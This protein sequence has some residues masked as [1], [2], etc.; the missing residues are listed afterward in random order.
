MKYDIS[1]VFLQYNP[2]S[3]KLISSLYSLINQKGIDFEIIITDDGSQEDYFDKIKVF[4]ERYHFTNYLLHKNH[5]NLGIVKNY[6]SGVEFAQGEYVFGNSPGDVLAN[7]YALRD[8]YN[9]AQKHSAKCL[10]AEAAYYEKV[11]D[12]YIVKSC[13]MDPPQPK[14]YEW[15]MPRCFGKIGL[16]CEQPILGAVF[17]RKKE[18]VEKYFSIISE[19]S[20]YVEDNTSALYS[21]MDGEKIVYFNKLVL[22]YET[23]S[24]KSTEVNTWWDK[25]LAEDFSNTKKLVKDIFGKDPLYDFYGG[26]N[27]KTMNVIKHPVL[28]LEGRIFNCFFPQ[29]KTQANKEIEYEINN[30]MQN[31]S[32]IIKEMD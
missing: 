18:Y 25:A 4:F 19:T 5:D 14:A 15:F 21:V 10:F 26:K 32:K 27:S 1:I 16:F 23:G 9:F 6:L 2:I 11:N 12:K 22:W 20:K 29:K 3:E 17:L 13:Y 28:Y 8:Y 30:Y 24:T 31:I 7:C